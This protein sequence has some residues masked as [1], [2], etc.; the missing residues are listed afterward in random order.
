MGKYPQWNDHMTFNLNPNDPQIIFTIKD[1]DP[2]KDDTI[3]Q[4]QLP[5]SVLQQHNST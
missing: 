3:G 2:G 1:S 4:G 5:I